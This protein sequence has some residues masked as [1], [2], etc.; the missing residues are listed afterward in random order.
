MPEDLNDFSAV[1]IYWRYFQPSGEQLASPFNK[2]FYLYQQDNLNEL[3]KNDLE[4]L[5]PHTSIRIK[6]K[7]KLGLHYQDSEATAS[8]QL[9]RQ[10]LDS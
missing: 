8:L 3:A 1:R 7:V 9:A 6:E 10:G 5:L 2:A 4:A